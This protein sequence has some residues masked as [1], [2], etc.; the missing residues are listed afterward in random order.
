MEY[1]FSQAEK[2][3]ALAFARA[4]AEKDGAYYTARGNKE[5]KVSADVTNGV[6]GEFAARALLQNTFPGA[7]VSEVDFT[8][9]KVGKKSYKPD[10]T[11]TVGDYAMGVQVKMHVCG[12]YTNIRPAFLFQKPGIGKHRDREILH[13]Q[14]GGSSSELF[15]GVLGFVTD[16][17]KIKSDGL[18]HTD[19]V[20]DEATVIGPFSMQTIVDMNLWQEPDALKVRQSGKKRALVAAE[21]CQKVEAIQGFA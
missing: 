8:V 11:V 21:L 2:D 18:V 6:L 7:E 15:V 9:H 17:D 16:P 5:A 20:A 1:V 3:A 13:I 19:A 12:R 4:R 14:P 10:F